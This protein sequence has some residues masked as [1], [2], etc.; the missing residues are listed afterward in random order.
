MGEWTAHK[1][2]WYARRFDSYRAKVINAM[3]FKTQGCPFDAYPFKGMSYR[4]MRGHGIESSIAK[5]CDPLWMT[6]NFTMYAL[7]H[8]LLVPGGFSGRDTDGMERQC[9]LAREEP[10]ARETIDLVDEYANLEMTLEEL[11]FQLP[12]WFVPSSHGFAR[13]SSFDDDIPETEYQN[14]PLCPS[15]SC[16]QPTFADELKA[17]DDTISKL[18]TSLLEE[19]TTGKAY[20]WESGMRLPEIR[21]QSVRD[22]DNFLTEYQNQYKTGRVAGAGEK[23][24]TGVEALQVAFSGEPGKLDPVTTPKAEPE[25]YQEPWEKV[26]SAGGL[27]RKPTGNEQATWDKLDDRDKSDLKWVLVAMDRPKPEVRRAYDRFNIQSK[28]SASGNIANILLYCSVKG[29]RIL[30]TSVSSDMRGH[31][32]FNGNMISQDDIKHGKQTA[33]NQINVISG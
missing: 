27:I 33:Q 12:P 16:K 31:L 32:L 5:G 19:W 4:F 14:I 13:N 20:R 30:D 17:E 29:I 7:K 24:G 9:M 15:Y 18:E 8:F 1:R 11:V 28:T 23:P 6:E 22:L 10:T 2:L 25:P 3:W 26:A 21:F